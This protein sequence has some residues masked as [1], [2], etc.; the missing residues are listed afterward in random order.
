MNLVANSRSAAVLNLRRWF[1]LSWL[2]FFQTNQ[3]IDLH[4]DQCSHGGVR[5]N[6]VLAAILT[7]RRSAEPVGFG[8]ATSLLAVCALRP[9]PPPSGGCVNQPVGSPRISVDQE[10]GLDRG[11]ERHHEGWRAEEEGQGRAGAQ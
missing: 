5:T 1:Q 8:G 3:L 10:C 7:F 6:V 11:Q 4:P 9:P 2:S